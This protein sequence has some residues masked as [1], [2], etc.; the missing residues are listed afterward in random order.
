MREV[1]LTQIQDNSTK[2]DLDLLERAED[3]QHLI[4]I[5]TLFFSGV[6]AHYTYN[7]TFILAHIF[8]LSVY[9]VI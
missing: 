4:M 8:S 1:I 3:F 6:A 2:L 5:G 9:N 7:N